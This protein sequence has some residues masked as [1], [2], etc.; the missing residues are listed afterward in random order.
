MQTTAPRTTEQKPSTRI[1]AS[2]PAQVGDG[3]FINRALPIA[4]QGLEAMEPF[5]MLDH[6]GPTTFGPTAKPRGVDVHPHKGFQTVTLAYQGDLVH[7]DSAGNRGELAPGDVQWMTAGRGIVHEEKHGPDL[8]RNGGVSEMV[9]LW[10]NLPA[11]DK[12]VAPHYTDF[13]AEVFPVIPLGGE[14]SNFVRLVAGRWD[15]Y[16]GPAKTYSPLT[17]ADLY[18][19]P[20]SRTTITLDPAW[21]TAIYALS[22]TAIVNGHTLGPNFIAQLTAEPRVDITVEATAHLLLLSA[23]PIGEPIASYGP[24]VMNTEDELRIAMREFQEGKMGT[25]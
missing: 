5:L 6:A 11:A 23:E 13:K 14:G 21:N 1:H 7:R 2:Q 15:T 25:L 16:R 9:Q 12:S 10:I 24:F 22:G 8:T 3:F 20:G 4:R 18:L 19:D 17:L